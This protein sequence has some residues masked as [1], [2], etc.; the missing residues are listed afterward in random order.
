M[1]IC[2]YVFHSIILSIYLSIY[3]S[4]YRS[5]SSK[6]TGH[7]SN[8][9]TL[10]AT[11]AGK[12]WGISKTGTSPTK[13]FGEPSEAWS[14]PLM[15]TTVMSVMFTLP[16][17]PIG[18]AVHGAG[19][20]AGSASHWLNDARASNRNHARFH[21]DIFWRWSISN[22]SSD[23]YS[24]SQSAGEFTDQCDRQ[25][26]QLGVSE[27]HQLTCIHGTL[28]RNVRVGQKNDKCFPVAFEWNLWS[29]WMDGADINWLPNR[30]KTKRSLSLSHTVWSH[31]NRRLHLS[32]YRSIYQSMCMYMYV[33]VCI[34]MYM[35]YMRLVLCTDFNTCIV[36][37]VDG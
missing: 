6:R 5:T 26:N 24:F 17:A 22:R 32:I 18:A 19:P 36:Y 8:L 14:I 31:W 28:T 2:L 20:T 29:T 21:G 11:P 34:C 33:Y 16:S 9:S 23:S 25:R 12:T 27:L 35:L 15:I 7:S 13:C 3:Q 37:N 30:I 4:I 1:S 10:P